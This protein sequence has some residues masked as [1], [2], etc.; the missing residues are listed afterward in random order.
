MTWLPVLQIRH[1]EDGE[2]GK[3]LIKSARRGDYDA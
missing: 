2:A 3:A 1:A